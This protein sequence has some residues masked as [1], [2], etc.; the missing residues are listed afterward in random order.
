MKS[1]IIISLVCFVAAVGLASFVIAPLWSSAKI[2]RTDIIGLKQEA[3]EVENLLAKSRQLEQK[4]LES[5]EE[6]LK[7]ILSLPEEEEISYLLVQFEGL[8]LQNGLLLEGIEFGKI[9]E[10]Q[11]SSRRSSVQSSSQE[12]NQ[13]AQ[14]PEGIATFSAN[15]R[16]VGS[17]EA[18][19]GYLNSLENNVRSMDI[20]QVNFKVFEEKED[21]SLEQ[22]GIFEFD[23]VVKVYYR[24]SI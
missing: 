22:S 23:L 5:K 9:E 21:G 6:A 4:Y 14:L 18:F 17:Y 13:G 3:V 1:K 12:T 16:A 11:A 24:P 19:K 10:V 15:I 7:I 20:E 2:L 8:A